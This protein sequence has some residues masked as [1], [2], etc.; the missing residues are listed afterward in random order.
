[1]ETPGLSQVCGEFM[2]PCDPEYPGS[3][4]RIGN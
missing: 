3:Q 1:V 4:G 2:S